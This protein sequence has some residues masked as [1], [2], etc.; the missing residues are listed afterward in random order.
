MKKQTVLVVFASFLYGAHALA[1]GFQTNCSS[2]DGA[3]STHDGHFANGTKLTIR[4]WD[5]K[6]KHESQLNYENFDIQQ[7]VLSKIEHDRKEV[8]K[9]I[10]GNDDGMYWGTVHTY[11]KI[12]FSLPG[13]TKFP[14]NVVGVS[15]DRKTVTAHLICQED[16]DSDISCKGTQ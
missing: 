12:E 16:V 4:F 2:A 5:A 15:T 8:K 10:P 6:G 13:G 3:T 14:E 11:Q 7:R 9:C 1:S